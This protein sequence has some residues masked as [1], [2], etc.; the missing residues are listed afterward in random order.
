MMNARSIVQLGVLTFLFAGAPALADKRC[1]LRMIAGQWVFAT[2][3]GRQALGEPFP[4]DKH[5]TAIGTMTIGRD[6][7][8]EGRYDA[9]V[10]ESMFLKD[11]PYTGTLTINEDC[12][13]ELTFETENGNARTDSIVVVSK[14]EI[15]GMS[16]DPNNLWTYQVR[17]VAGR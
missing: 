17:R 8:V 3:I 14:S 12:T 9:T 10:Q 11:I 13:G 7:H 6:G 1:N 5:L 15:L 4:P 16:R 2:E